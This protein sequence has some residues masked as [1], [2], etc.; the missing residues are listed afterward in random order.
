[1]FIYQLWLVLYASNFFSPVLASS[2]HTFQYPI[3]LGFEVELSLPY[4]EQIIRRPDGHFS[5]DQDTGQEVVMST[6]YNED[7]IVNLLT[8]VYD[9]KTKLCYFPRDAFV[10]PEDT[11]TRPVGS[12]PR[13]AFTPTHRAEFEQINLDP[14]LVSLLERLP[15]QR[16]DNFES[17]TLWHIGTVAPRPFG[18]GLF[19][20]K[21]LYGDKEEP[22]RAAEI[23]LLVTYERDGHNLVLN[24]E[25]SKHILPPQMTQTL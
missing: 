24:V 2:N 4:R 20:R 19:Y 17:Y 10:Y 3:E 14:R 22:L 23:T 7:V 16:E 25:D 1:M 18:Q 15:Y 6:T 13:H 12:K 9:L 21:L 11:S 5:L 8:Q